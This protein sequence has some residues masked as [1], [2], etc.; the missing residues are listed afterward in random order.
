MQQIQQF[1]INHWALWLAFL[2]LLI[3]IIINEVIAQKQKAK[4]LSPTEAVDFINHQDAVVI[5]IRDAES[6]Q[7]GHII[8]S[9]RATADE[10]AQPRME[11]YKTKPLILVCNRGIQAAN[12]AMQLRAQGFTQA[13]VLSGG[14]SAWTGADLPLAKGKAS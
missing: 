1:I 8:N 6:F 7:K 5:D 11:K 12:L 13:M 3:L 14:L 2:T 9:I 4:A 10:F